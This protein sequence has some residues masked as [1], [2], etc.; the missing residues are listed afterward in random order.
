MPK[1]LSEIEQLYILSL[2]KKDEKQDE[3]V[4]EFIPSELN[5]H[6]IIDDLE[7]NI[8]DSL[9]QESKNTEE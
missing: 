2:L 9:H 6:K 7:N 1:D 4:E 3:S 8:L 5:I